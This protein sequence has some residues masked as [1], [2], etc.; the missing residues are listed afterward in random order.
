VSY[1]SVV[2]A[3][4]PTHWYRCSDTGGGILHDSTAGTQRALITSGGFVQLAY[5]G[6][7]TGGGSVW[8]DSNIFAWHNEADQQIGTPF[9]FELCVWR[10]LASGLVEVLLD[11]LAQ[12]S[13]AASG[14][15]NFS[16]RAAFTVVTPAAISEQ[17]W[18]HIV[19]T[20]GPAGGTKIYV[21]GVNVI[22]NAS[23]IVA[24]PVGRAIALGASAANA[25]FSHANISEAAI[26]S[27]ELSAA[28]VTAHF[29]ALDLIGVK[30][31]SQANGTF[32]VVTGTPG[33][34]GADLAAILESV[35]ATY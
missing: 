16:P 24:A 6:P 2:A 20:Y 19:G 34:T 12:I 29:N 28:Q 10:H 9:S 3:D 17:A 21:D 27:A 23:F 11:Q 15:I 26:Y 30:P 5:T 35:R 8:I 25:N 14:A 1:Q 22:T 13:I 18:H 31:I 4:A 32:D 33:F 7:A